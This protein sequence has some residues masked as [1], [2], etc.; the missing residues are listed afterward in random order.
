VASRVLLWKNVK[1]VVEKL[2][3]T[4]NSGDI[5]IDERVILK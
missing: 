5:G 2:Q 1:A 4:D 3:R